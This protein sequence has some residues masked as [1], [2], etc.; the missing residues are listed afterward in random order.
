MD[1]L[2]GRMDVFTPRGAA[3]VGAAR[4]PPQFPAGHLGHLQAMD[5]SGVC[6]RGGFL[7]EGC[8]GL[9]THVIAPGMLF[10]TGALPAFLPGLLSAD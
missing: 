8:A 3:S 1:L 9:L 2:D 7:T 5:P 10:T 6:R 4:C